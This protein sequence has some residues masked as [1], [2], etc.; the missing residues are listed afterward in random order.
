[1]FEASLIDLLAADTDLQGLLTTFSSEPA[2]FTGAAPQKAERPYIIFDIDKNSVEN[3]A[4]SGFNIVLDIYIREES[5]KEMREIAE[6]IEFVCDRAVIMNDVGGR[7]QAIRLFYEDGREVE[8]SDVK[9]RHYV[10]RLSARAGR[11][12][13]AEETISRP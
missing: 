9:I 2:I 10:V 8:N 5:G 11:K 13:W 3:L 7:F 4:A 6:R 1:M 12:K